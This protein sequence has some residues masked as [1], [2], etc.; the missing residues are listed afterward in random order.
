MKEAEKGG[1]GTERHR[2]TKKET[3]N[4]SSKKAKT[5]ERKKG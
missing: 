4:H 2:E 1:R 5:R 3:N